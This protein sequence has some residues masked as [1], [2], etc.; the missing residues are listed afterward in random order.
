LFLVFRLNDYA[1]VIIVK[2]IF[3]LPL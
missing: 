3:H 1:I 2:K